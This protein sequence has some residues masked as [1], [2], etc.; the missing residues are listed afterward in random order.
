[1]VTPAEI[2][3]PVI[4]FVAEHIRSLDELELLLL[5]QQTPDRWWD[6]PAV[7]RE[8]AMDVD[9]ARRALERFASRN[10]LAIAVT[11][12]VRY[13][14]Q[15]GEP[16]LREVAEAFNAAYR[17]NRLAILHLVTGRPQQ[18]IR[19]FAKA[20]RIRRDDDR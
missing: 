13:R 18:S 4:Q 11:G 20:F 16:H 10:L 14:F 1:M 2:P 15:P 5:L 19:D 6:A 7:A 9:S 3:A 12:D 8:L 17:A